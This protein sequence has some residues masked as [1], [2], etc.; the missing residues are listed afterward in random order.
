MHV[1]SLTHN[2]LQYELLVDQDAD[3]PNTPEH[4]ERVS[5]YGELQHIF[6]LE[7][8]QRTPRINPGK[9]DHILLLVLI[10]KAPTK[11]DTSDEYE[12]TVPNWK[13]GSRDSRV[14]L[15]LEAVQGI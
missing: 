7:I 12:V 3:K 4:L 15:A 14:G 2:I 5:Q 8:K 13:L 10:H 6:A 9:H 11:T 1:L